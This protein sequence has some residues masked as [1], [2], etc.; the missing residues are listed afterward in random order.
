MV[1][2]SIVTYNHNLQDIEQALHSLLKSSVSHIYIIDHS[3][4]NSEEFLTSLKQYGIAQMTKDAEIRRRCQSRQLVLSYHKHEN[5]G[6][7]G[8]HNIAIELAKQAGANYH[9]VVNPDV[10]FE[11]DIVAEMKAYMDEHEDVGQMMPRVLFPDGSIQRL[12]KLLPTPIDM[13][14]RLCL[15][16][17]IANKRNERYELRASGY[18]KI[19][20]VPYLSGCFMF[21][22]LSAISKVGLFDEHFFM[23][24]EDIDMTRR[25]NEQFKTLYFPNVTIYH[26]F[27]RASRH[28]LKLLFIHIANIFMYFN[29]YGWFH[30]SHRKAVNKKTLEECGYCS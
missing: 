3:D 24:A 27:S 18:D 17:F 9:I 28:S 30:D 1:T 23:Y 4:K 29:K 26:R 20:N 22:R 7:G 11:N 14:R 21:F 6:Y 8:G 25:M 13:V 10:W 19:M 12:C 5:V 2:A 16:S 15:P